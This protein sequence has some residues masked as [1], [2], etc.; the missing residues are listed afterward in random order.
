VDLTLDHDGAQDG[1]FYV[2]D[3]LAVI[4]S[5]TYKFYLPSEKARGFCREQPTDR[6]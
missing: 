1:N 4:T 2:D 6:R 5:P 3:I